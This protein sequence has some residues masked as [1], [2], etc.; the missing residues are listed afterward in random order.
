MLYVSL[1]RYDNCSFF[2]GSPD[3]DY[4]RI[5]NGDGLGYNVNVAWH[6]V[7]TRTVCVV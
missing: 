3:A 1:H 7:S 2:P 4:D 6:D 5:G